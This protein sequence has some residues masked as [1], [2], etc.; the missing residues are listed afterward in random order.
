[1]LKVRQ[2]PA[3]LTGSPTEAKTL[4]RSPST[5]LAIDSSM[6]RMPPTQESYRIPEVKIAG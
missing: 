5:L 4:S 2:S 1:M 3:T 6:I